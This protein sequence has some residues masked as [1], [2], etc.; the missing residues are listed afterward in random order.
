MLHITETENMKALNG[1]KK[2][3]W[4]R[5][6]LRRKQEHHLVINLFGDW[7]EDRVWVS[8]EVSDLASDVTCFPCVPHLTQPCF[9]CRRHWEKACELVE[10]IDEC[11]HWGRN[12]KQR[13][14]G[15]AGKKIDSWESMRK[16]ESSHAEKETKDWILSQTLSTE[17]SQGGLWARE[18]SYQRSTF[19]R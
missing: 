14:I 8:L 3:Q 16:N 11:D 2:K 12:N 13:F 4:V 15:K 17:S 19:E 6:I 7:E 9:I 18:W 1:V 10:W 5:E